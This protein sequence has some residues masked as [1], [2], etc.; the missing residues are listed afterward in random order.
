MRI[1]VIG[2]GAMG[3]EHIRNIALLGRDAARVVAVADSDGRARTEAVSELGPDASSCR[4]FE[5]YEELLACDLV[6]S[7][8]VC[9]PNFTHIDVLR[10]A[11]PT[12]KHIL[13]E[14][15]L[16]TTVADCEEVERL[17]AEREAVAQ[18]QGTMVGVFM[19]GMEYRWM[20]PIANLI[21][22]TDSGVHGK[23][24]VLTVREHRFP[25]LIKVDNWNRFNRY[26]GGTLVEK[27]CHF[28]DLMRRIVHSEPVS[29]YATGGQALNHKEEVYDEGSPDIIDHALATVEFASGARA[30]LDLCMF[31]E[32]EQM[33]MVTAVCEKGKIEA[34][35]PESTVRVIRRMHLA[36]PGRT[37][38]PRDN[39]AV[40]EVRRLEVP[41]DLAKAGYHEGAT[42]FELRAFVEAA[43]GL[44]PVPVT[45]RDGKM[46]V[47]MGV[48]A[49][50][51]ISIGQV[52]R[53]D[54][55]APALGTVDGTG[56]EHPVAHQLAA[57]IACVSPV[58]GARL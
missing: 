49:Q 11:I 2:T 3:K 12:G 52:V 58:E 6:D 56:D 8:V 50:E 32:D 48:A 16:C 54:K 7:I 19:T 30:T 37:P 57:A 36:T 23:V 26:T 20:P 5:R 34:H 28:F 46:A 51:S 44:R 55:S 21:E 39:R 53:M 42:F 45:A 22:E 15:P 33:E 40:P 4:V 38:P 25:F 35:A 41:E 14:K 17:V 31:A 18:E 13:C 9:T 43:R 10:Q 24:H 1:G 29:V 47:A 27:A